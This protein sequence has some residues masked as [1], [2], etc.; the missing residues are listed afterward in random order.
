MKA[1]QY[2]NK[3]CKTKEK[4]KKKGLLSRAWIKRMTEMGVC[5]ET[6]NKKK[7]MKNE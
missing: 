6:E 1:T 7:G 5:S 4:V 3:G 2:K